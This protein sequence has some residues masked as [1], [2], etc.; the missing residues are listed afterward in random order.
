[1]R[2]VPTVRSGQRLVAQEL[3]FRCFPEDEAAISECK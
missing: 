1:M 2:G 3:H